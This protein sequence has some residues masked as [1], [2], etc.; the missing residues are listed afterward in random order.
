MV[1]HSSPPTEGEIR[2]QLGDD[3]LNSWTQEKVSAWLEE[4]GWGQFVSTFESKTC[5]FLC[6]HVYFLV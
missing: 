4:R 1:K 3:M 6:R 5:F 2:N